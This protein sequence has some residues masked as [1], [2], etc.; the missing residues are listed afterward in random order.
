MNL[1]APPLVRRDEHRGWM[2]DDSDHGG[3]LRTR[4]SGEQRVTP[5]EL[6]F[7]LV[8]VFAVTQLSHLLLDHLSLRG[9]LETLMLFLAVWGA[10]IYTAWFTNW[11]HPDRLS[12]RLV[13]VAVM[14]ASLLMSVAIPEAFGK[15]G[16]LFALA[17]VAIQV[18]RTAFTVIA[19]R[20]SL[21]ISHPLSKTFQRILIW[22]VGS[23]VVW[24]I[25]GLLEGEARYAVWLLALAVDFSGPVV[26]YYIPALGRSRTGEWNIEG[27]HFAERCQLFVIIALGESILVTGTTFAEIEVSAG[28]V[29]AFVV[30]FLGSVAL[31]WIYFSRSAEAAREVFTSSEDPGRLGRSAYTYFHMPMIA[32]IIAIAAAD[33]LT[34]AHPG[35]PG[36]LASIA[37]TL[38]GTALF[39]AGLAL[40]KWAVFGV[41][42]FS[43]AVAVAALM[44]LIPVG[45][46]IPALALSGAAGLIVVGLAVWETL[47]YSHMRSPRR[48]T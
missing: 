5:L 36:T 25:G 26:G 45:F 37:L 47:A 3:P 12:V 14:L 18:G 43:H 32:G 44:A 10:W 28:A 34:V 33:E 42:P 31:W 19:L 9:L 20:K 39:L 22:F 8:Y 7:D 24:I 38:G 2:M 35:D 15:R 30:A 1:T 16:L 17:Y 40:F 29:L 13:L 21:G 23:G 48:A 46:A 27:G 6:F 4:D 41:L 11:F